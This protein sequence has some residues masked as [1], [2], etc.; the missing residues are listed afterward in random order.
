MSPE[1]NE[2]SPKFPGRNRNKKQSH[3]DEGLNTEFHPHEN[4]HLAIPLEQLEEQF[5]M[6][7]RQGVRIIVPKILDSKALEELRKRKKGV[8]PEQ[9]LAG[10][11]WQHSARNV[12][13][14]VY[15]SGDFMDCLPRYCKGPIAC[16]A[17]GV[18]S[19]T[20]VTGDS[21]GKPACAAISLATPIAWRVATPRSAS[22]SAAPLIIPW[23]APR[24][25]S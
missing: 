25:V 4:Y 15:E 23:L 20:I 22:T 12:R 3:P 6:N 14:N 19:A 24:M 17:C 9:I 11:I 8:K 5:R 7:V 13:N 10:N 18:P 2:E 16:A 21:S 1:N